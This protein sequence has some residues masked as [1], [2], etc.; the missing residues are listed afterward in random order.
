MA[1]IPVVYLLAR[2]TSAKLGV[3]DAR[4]LRQY[5][6]V[7]GLRSFF[8]GSTET[9]ANSYVNAVGRNPEDR[10]KAIGALLGRVPKNRLFCISKEDVRSTAGMYSPLMQVYLVYL[11][12]RQ[13]KSWPSGRTLRDVMHE[14]QIGDPLAVHHIFPKKLMQDRD[15][16]IER[17]NTV[18]NYAILSQADNAELGDRSPLD[19]WRSLRP[20]QQEWASE[21]LCFSASENLLK[22][23]AYDEFIDYRSAKLAERLNEFLNLKHH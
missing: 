18:A 10:A 7:S 9:T 5:L 4:L 12:D 19:V 23:E 13:A 1:L 2:T 17:L 16:P 11:Q 21:Q 14:T 3:R 20:T 8:R 22:P 15:V 6:A